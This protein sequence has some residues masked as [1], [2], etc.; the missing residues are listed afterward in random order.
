MEEAGVRGTVRLRRLARSYTARTTA[1]FPT[2]SPYTCL[3]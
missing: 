1:V 2:I 3:K